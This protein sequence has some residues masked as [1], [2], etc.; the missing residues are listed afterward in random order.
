MGCHG[1]LPVFK[2]K[3]YTSHDI[4]AI[5]RR[6]TKQKKAGHTGTL[7]PEVEGVLPV[8][9][10][11]ATRLVE[12]LQDR[13]KRYQ[14]TLKLGIATETEDQTGAV[15]AQAERVEPVE[16][17]QVEEVFSRF[18]GEITQVPPMYSAVKVNGRRL[19]EWAREGKEI[20]RPKRKVH[21]YELKQTGMT[22]GEYP[23]IHF[24]VLCS[25]GTYIRTLCVDIGKA[26]GYPAH[27]ASLVRVQSGPFHL[28][29]CYT[30]DELKQ[31]G[32][33][34]AWEKHVIRLDEGISFMP[35]MMVN[36]EDL[37]K[38]YDG[39]KIEIPVDD[40]LFNENQL[41]RVYTDAGVFCA[42]YR[43]IEKGLAKPE[44]V[45]RDVE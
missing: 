7:D 44:K 45:F 9:L 21:I 23:E 26:L 10:G 33:Q 32:E 40:Q 34:E 2:P 20:D 13:P 42:V 3:N 27:M 38:V 4:V 6:L 11:Q 16:P 5:V 37:R 17:A 24:E 28:E 8:C 14:G 19:Y 41:V 29:D 18:V 22:P 12:Y 31:I 15:I 35:G 25:K 39:W 43:V 36:H 30:L 1:I